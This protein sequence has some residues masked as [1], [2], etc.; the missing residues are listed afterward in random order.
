MRHVQDVLAATEGGEVNDTQMLDWLEEQSRKSYTGISFD[1]HKDDENHR[2]FRFMRHHFI[3]PDSLTIRGAIL[4][5]FHAPE[6]QSDAIERN[7]DAK[8]DAKP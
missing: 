3:G 6:T 8:Q 2:W 1:C 7:P 4:N 5:A